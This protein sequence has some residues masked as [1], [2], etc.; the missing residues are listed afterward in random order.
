MIHLSVQLVII[1]LVVICCSNNVICSKIS[2]ERVT[3]RLI[4]SLSCSIGLFISS[5]EQSLATINDPASVSRFKQ[6]YD[7][8]QSLD[9][10]WNSVV[11]DS[12]DNIRRVLGTVYANPCSVSLCSFPTFITKFAKA[13]AEELGVC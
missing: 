1:L 12:G 13:N 5:P 10:N 3:V 4:S 11:K 2:V 8:L 9:K 7:D 6:G